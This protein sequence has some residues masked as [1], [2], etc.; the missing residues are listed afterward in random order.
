MVFPF[1]SRDIVLLVVVFSSMAAGICCPDVF[2]FLQPYPLLC[3]MVLFFMSFLSIRIEAVWEA[4]RQASLSILSLIV[5]KMVVLPIALYA[6]F[7]QVIP[8]YAVAALLLTGVST[9]VVAP[10]MSNL[11]GGNSARVLVV[12]VITSVLV[13]FSLPSIVG[14]VLSKTV[15]LSFWDML[16]VLALAIFVPIAAVQALRRLAP[17]LLDAVNRRSYP[18]NLVMFALINLGVFSNYADIFRRDPGLIVE[19]ALVGIVLSGVY[20]TA[21]ILFFRGR[22]VEDRLA[23]AVMLAHMNNIL[24]VVFSSRFFGPHE[25]MMAAMYLLPF[26]GL[27]LPLR[28]YRDRVGK[29]PLP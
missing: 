7:L 4:L 8:D 1:R 20:S 13:P 9:G 25:T 3:L 28:V 29:R 10:F 24:M 23:G 16:H 15:H 11:V 21:G 12:T 6:L 14:L 17:R 18:V 26:F 5:L 22:P 2:A 19:A 27:V